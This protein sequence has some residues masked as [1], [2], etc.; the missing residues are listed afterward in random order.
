MRPSNDRVFAVTGTSIGAL[1]YLTLL[2][3]V[4]TTWVQ[5]RFQKD[6]TPTRAVMIFSIEP[7]WASIIAAVAIGETLTGTGI[8]GGALILGG[9]LLSELSE[10]I[11]VLSRPLVADQP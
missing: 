10:R 6:T 9:V 1:L 8:A 7:V 11:P 3:T 2:A 5:S 4:L